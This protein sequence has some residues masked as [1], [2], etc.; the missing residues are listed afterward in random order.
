MQR[1]SVRYYKEKRVRVT[2]TIFQFVGIRNEWMKTIGVVNVSTELSWTISRNWT[3]IFN[4]YTISM[5]LKIYCIIS[6]VLFYPRLTNCWVML[7]IISLS[8]NLAPLTSVNME[9]ERKANK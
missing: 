8:P 5:L 1:E 2:L 6:A 3:E 4:E 7:A 9:E